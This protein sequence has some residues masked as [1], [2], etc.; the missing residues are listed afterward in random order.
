MVEKGQLGR[1]EK[2]KDRLK[3]IRN[4]EVNK[5]KPSNIVDKVEVVRTSVGTQ[6]DYLSDWLAPG[7]FPGCC[8]PTP[9]GFQ[10]NRYFSING[11]LIFVSPA[12]LGFESIGSSS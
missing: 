2:L 7:Y 12:A 1:T 10:G 3:N 6:T 5:P 9:R 11:S 4:R 8:S